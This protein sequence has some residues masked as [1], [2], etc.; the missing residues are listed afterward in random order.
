MYLN[1]F[2][3]NKMSHLSIGPICFPFKGCWLVFFIVNQIFIDH[4]VGE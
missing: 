3:S 4:S 1:P 2:T